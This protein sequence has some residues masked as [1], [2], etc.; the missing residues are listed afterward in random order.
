MFVFDKESRTMP[1]GYVYRTADI[2]T[3]SRAA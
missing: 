3:L 2:S 1:F